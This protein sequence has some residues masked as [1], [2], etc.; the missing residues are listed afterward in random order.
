[1][2]SPSELVAHNRDPESVAKHTGADSVIYQTLDDL[3]GACPEI[4][5]ENGLAEPDRFEVGVF[6]GNYITPVSDGYFDHLE[7]V[8]GESRKLKVMEIG[9]KAVVSGVA[10][11]QDVQVAANGVNMDR[12][13]E[14][15]CGNPT[16]ELRKCT[17]W[18]PSITDN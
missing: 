8:R 16:A 15:R 18:K 7:K 5:R 12:A 17:H 3:K 9:R 13:G 2:A 6:C 4:L 14:S 10:S 11:R 1:M